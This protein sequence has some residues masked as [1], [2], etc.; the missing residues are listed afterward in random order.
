MSRDPWEIV[1]RAHVRALNV[2]LEEFR[3]LMV[4][5]VAK[6]REEGGHALFIALS[7][8]LGIERG[9]WDSAEEAIPALREAVD[10]L[11]AAHAAEITKL[12]AELGRVRADLASVSAKPASTSRPIRVPV[13]SADANFSTDRGFLRSLAWVTGQ[14]CLAVRCDDPAPLDRLAADA[15][16]RKPE[17]DLPNEDLIAE[18]VTEMP[19]LN[20]VGVTVATAMEGAWPRVKRWKVTSS[21]QLDAFRWVTTVQFRRL[22]DDE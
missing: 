14:Q 19:D 13:S 8:V 2:A 18:I 15:R 16:T 11:K 9:P 3:D 21:P 22:Y 6:D 7:D 17:R 4:V 20:A 10:R 1:A 12:Q 5:E